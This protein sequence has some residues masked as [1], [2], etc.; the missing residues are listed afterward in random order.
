MYARSLV[1]FVLCTALVIGVGVVLNYEAS[2]VGNQ[3][4]SL[5]TSPTSCSTSQSSCPRFSI[6]SAELDTMN[7]TDQLGVA[8]PDYLTLELDVQGPSSLSSIHLFVGN[9]SAGSVHGPFGPGLDRIANIT[10][11]S[12]ASVSAGRTYHV[13]V[14]AIGSGGSYVLES[15]D[16]VAQLTTPYPS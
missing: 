3:I 13:T 15:V 11:Q 5:P 10:L 12:T 16:V 14:E 4:Q 8:N 1:V 7:T 2:A 9:A 6:I